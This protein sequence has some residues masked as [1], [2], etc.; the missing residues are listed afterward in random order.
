MSLYVNVLI[1][2]NS[3]MIWVNVKVICLIYIYLLDCSTNCLT[4][5]I[6][7]NNCLSCDETKKYQLTN[8]IC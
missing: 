2:I 1:V 6:N 3:L 5:S 7:A 4:C 8:N